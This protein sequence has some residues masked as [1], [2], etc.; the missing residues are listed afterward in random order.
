MSRLLLPA[1]LAAFSLAFAPAASA[2]TPVQPTPSPTPAPEP[3]PAE[4][5]IA[6]GVS[7]GDVDVSNLTLSE[8]AAKLEPA[9]A[10]AY[11]KNV[12]VAVAGKR[13]KLS[14]KAM[15]LVFDPAKS[16]RR[17]Y[18]AGR[19]TPPADGTTVAVAP[20]VTFRRAA[21]RDFA[22]R[23][24]RRVYVPARNA[25][26]RI[27]LRK[28]YRRRSKAGRDLDARGLRSTIEKTLADP[29]APRI[30]KPGRSKVRAAINANDLRKRYRTIITI[31]RSSFKLR[32]FKNLK[33]RKSYGV[34]VGAAGYDTP[35][36]LYSIQNK[37]VN[38]AWSAPDKPWAGLYRGKTVAGG[39]PENPLKARWLGIAN[40]VGIHGTGDP[41][42]IGSRASHGCIRMRVP[43]VIDLFPRVPVGTPVLIGG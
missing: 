31:D 19:G 27:T 28:I 16:A 29:T 5:R 1:V 7:V 36:G 41:G 40:G 38:P 2:Q 20:F 25:T 21:V 10:P 24:D 4:P 23:V 42:S 14:P 43:D 13:F 26:V 17:A 30:L 34:A 6:Q 39:S 32:L 35:R 15:R 3:A 12:I 37:Q 22:N 33:L 8:A 11:A 9:L 18:I